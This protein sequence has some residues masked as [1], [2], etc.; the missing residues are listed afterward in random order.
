MGREF[1][2]SNYTLGEKKG[3]KKK[4]LNRPSHPKIVVKNLSKRPSCLP[5][6]QP[7]KNYSCPLDYYWFLAEV[8]GFFVLFFFTAVVSFHRSF[9]P[10]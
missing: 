9:L 3:K 7:I 6:I 10:H 4:S 5:R 1:K 8:F 2:A